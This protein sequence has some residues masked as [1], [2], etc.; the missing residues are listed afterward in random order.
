M[1][2]YLFVARSVTHA[3]QM[4]RVLEQGGVSVR[5]RRVGAQMSAHGCGYTLQI[6]Q[7]QYDQA[8]R[9]LKKAGK[10]PLKVLRSSGGKLREVV[11]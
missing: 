5:I 9:L 2:Y 6:A 1:E 10:L 11:I 7:R 4:A 3:Q 8:I